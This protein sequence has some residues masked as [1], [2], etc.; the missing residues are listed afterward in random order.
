[1]RL[2]R[3]LNYN[4]S[5]A[6]QSGDESDSDKESNA[7]QSSNESESTLEPLRKKLR[8]STE[9]GPQIELKPITILVGDKDQE[10][11]IHE[12][13]LSSTSAFFAKV[14]KDDWK[15]G[16]DRIVKLPDVEPSVFRIWMKWLYTGRLFVKNE[17]DD[18]EDKT[19]EEHTHLYAC[20]ALGDFLQDLDFK[21][22]TIDAFIENMVECN[23]Y[24]MALADHIYGHSK[25]GSRHR[26]LAVDCFVR[27]WDRED[28][29]ELV[30]EDQDDAFQPPQFLC[31][32]LIQIGP[33]LDKGV[34]EKSIP[35]LFDLKDTCKYHDHGSD[36]PC[37]KTKPA[38]LF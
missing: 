2:R 37:Y 34:E 22:A 33:A 4:E 18:D 17:Q 30:I 5:Y 24:F 3:P 8:F 25:K 6:S 11:Y 7:S 28:W 36:K 9:E 19:D 31:D 1:M 27:L 13:L 20:Y 29:T 35:E 10:F 23:E 14:L 16:H 32:V 26:E 38:F 21:D 15:E 12:K